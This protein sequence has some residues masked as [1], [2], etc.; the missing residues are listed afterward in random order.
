MQQNKFETTHERIRRILSTPS[1]RSK[2]GTDLENMFMNLGLQQHEATQL[3]EQIFISYLTELPLAIIE[4][5]AWSLMQHC[6]VKLSDSK[7]SAVSIVDVFNSKAKKRLEQ[8]FLQ[9]APLLKDFSGKVIDYGAGDGK[10]AQMLHDNLH[11][12]IEGFDIRAV[13]APEVTIPIM[14]FDG[15]RV[16]VPDKYYSAG[17][18]NLVLHHEANNEKIL[19]ELNRIVSDKLIIKENVPSG[20]S[21]DVMLQDMD[22]TFILDYFMAKLF[23]NSDMPVPGAFE[24]PTRWKQRFAKYGWK[25]NFEQDL[26]FDPPYIPIRKYLFSFVR[27]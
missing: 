17:I 11:I 16:P 7:N 14:Q 10:F 3:C 19:H 15:V 4:Q 23:R 26:G 24:T 25:V 21:E 2:V 5:L 27:G 13:K 20:N 12:V 1:E 8:T 6:V 22:R 18:V 9:Y